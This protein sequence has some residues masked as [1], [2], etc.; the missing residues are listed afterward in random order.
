MINRLF[1]QKRQDWYGW[2]YFLYICIFNFFLNTIVYMARNK[3]SDEYSSDW[4]SVSLST[5]LLE[6][7]GIWILWYGP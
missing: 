1:K 2:I 6:L 3:F 4:G 7:K 5:H